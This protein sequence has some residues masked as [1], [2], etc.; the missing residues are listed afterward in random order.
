MNIDSN[1]GFDELKKGYKKEKNIFRCLFCEHQYLNGDIYSFDNRLV[2]ASTAIELH[3]QEAHGSVFDVLISG[4]KKNTG[5]TSVQSELLTHFYS[6]ISDKEIA[7]K[8]NTSQST[9]R[10]Q[11]FNLKEKARQAKVFLAL[12]ELMNEKSKEEHEFEI[13]AG[14][15][16]VDE[17]YMTSVEET[18]RIIE[19]FFSSINPLVLKTF[20]PKEKKKLVILKV[21]SEQFEKEKRYDEKEVNNILK[22]IYDDYATIRRYLIEYGFMERT[23]NCTEYWLK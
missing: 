20:S 21:I 22:S 16:M 5:L 14:A 3:M 6:G 17:R 10:Y 23:Q 15:T 9:V 8:T 7:A 19:T 1:V 13:H 4:N 11:R 2:E 12:F 18:Q